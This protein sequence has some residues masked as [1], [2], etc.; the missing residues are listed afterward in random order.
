MPLL[1]QASNGVSGG[2]PASFTPTGGTAIQ[3]VQV[4][5]LLSPFSGAGGCVDPIALGNFN[6]LV[7]GRNLLIQNAQYNF[8]QFS[9]QLVSS[10]QLNGSLT[11]SLASGLIGYE[12]WQFGPYRYYVGNASRSLAAEDGVARA[13]QVIGQNTSLVAIDLM[14]FCSFEKSIV[15]DI[16]SGARVA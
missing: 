6:I 9:Q 5:S 13:V 11:T 2:A 16:R 15:I 12:D 14:I 4:S 3:P 10:N 1:S 8:E 7:S